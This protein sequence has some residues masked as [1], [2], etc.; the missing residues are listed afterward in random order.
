MFPYKLWQ[1][2]QNK[3]WR[4]PQSAFMDYARQ[5]GYQPLRKVLAKYLRVSRSVRVSAK[6]I[7]IV[8]GTQQSLDL[9]ETFH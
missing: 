3:Y 7:L 1:K 6:Q 9:A 4:V 2:L 5:G 8:A